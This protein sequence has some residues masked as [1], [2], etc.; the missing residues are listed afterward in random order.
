MIVNEQKNIVK[1]VNGVLVSVENTITTIVKHVQNLVI[2]VLK[3][4]VKW[5]LRIF[6]SPNILKNS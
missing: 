1:F 2:N 4:V 3:N 5:Q 6:P